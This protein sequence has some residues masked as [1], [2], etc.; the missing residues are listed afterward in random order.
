M[1]KL[2]EAEYARYQSQILTIREQVF[3]VEQGVPVELEVDEL[4][5]LSRHVLLFESDTAVATG[6]LTPDGHIGRIAVLKAYRNKGFGTQIINKLESL[7]ASAGLF[8][9]EL[10]AQCQAVPFYE[11][12]NYQPLGGVFMDAGI[13]HQLMQKSLS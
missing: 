9:V 8:R 10:G 3:I 1:P 2:I 13:E 4:D 5:P 12:L 11:Q 7:A 6:R